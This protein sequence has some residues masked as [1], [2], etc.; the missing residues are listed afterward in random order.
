MQFTQVHRIEQEKVFISVQNNQG[1]ALEPSYVT[2]FSATTTDA[3][4]GRL[5]EL[6]DTAVSLVTG[7]GAAVAGVVETTIA[8][9]EVGRVQVYGPANIRAGASIVASTGM[10]ATDAGLA[11]GYTASSDSG[12]AYSDAFLGWT[13]ENGPNATNSTVFLKCL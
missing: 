2:E 10:V 7:I 3:D 5:V 1:A 6:T 9:G 4:Q 11:A 13:L 12:A 8:T